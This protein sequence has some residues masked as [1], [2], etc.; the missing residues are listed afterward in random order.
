MYQTH[1]GGPGAH[2]VFAQALCSSDSDSDD[3]ETPLAQ[4]GSAAAAGA[5]MIT[6]MHNIRDIAL[7][8]AT[9]ILG[10]RSSSAP[11]RPAAMAAPAPLPR[12]VRSTRKTMHVDQPLLHS[13]G[14]FASF[15]MPRM[16]SAN[17]Q[18]ERP[19]R[20]P[21]PPSAQ[22][23]PAERPPGHRSVFQLKK[24][25]RGAAPAAAAAGSGCA[26]T[27]QRAPTPRKE[28][29]LAGARCAD[30]P[31]APDG[32]SAEAR[33]QRLR[34]LLAGLDSLAHPGVAAA[35]AVPLS[36]ALAGLDGSCRHQTSAEHHT[37]PWPSPP[38][39][40][41]SPSAGSVDQ[42]RAQ[43]CAPE[44]AAQNGRLAPRERFDGAFPLNLEFQDSGN[45]SLGVSPPRI[46]Q[47]GG[48]SNRAMALPCFGGRSPSPPSRLAP[49][50]SFDF[51]YEMD[52]T[53][54]A[55]IKRRWHIA[56]K[57]QTLARQQ[58]IA[59]RDAWLPGSDA[60][61]GSERRSAGLG[62]SPEPSSPSGLFESGLDGLFLVGRARSR[63]DGPLPHVSPLAAPFDV[64]SPLRGSK[65]SSPSLQLI[66]MPRGHLRPRAFPDASPQF[67]RRAYE[68]Q[69][70]SPGLSV[71]GI[72]T[73]DG[74]FPAPAERAIPRE[75]RPALQQDNTLASLPPF[76]FLGG[77]LGGGDVVCH[78]TKRFTLRSVY[79]DEETGS[80]A[81][82]APPL[83]GVAAAAELLRLSPAS[84]SGAQR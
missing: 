76:G 40:Q 50:D 49:L 37:S 80:A 30:S 12:A 3:S 18:Q 54:G 53:R 35:P 60:S 74:F 21:E 68:R 51:G 34:Q 24:A 19:P 7:R 44:H 31:P 69:A 43:R 65:L 75:Q 6:H 27:A 70:G 48:R 33:S 84:A 28:Q 64:S 61:N 56:A 77:M 4:P 41:D 66:P 29:P 79:L 25:S 23:R 57:Q 36:R 13:A 39:S 47:G 38:A 11:R 16:A 63:R 78:V 82:P 5:N 20:V 22:E 46:A 72:G 26:P 67:A 9:S 42:A 10:K 2:A 55:G 1:A 71:C 58:A 62:T 8:N 83:V 15:E 52:S 73:I 45:E 14:I 32:Q 17:G 81:L 59:C